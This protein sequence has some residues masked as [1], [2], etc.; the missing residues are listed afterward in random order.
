[1]EQN[2]SMLNLPPWVNQAQWEHLE[3]RE[4]RD[5]L[6][7][8][9]GVATYPCGTSIREELALFKN[10]FSDIDL[11]N[12]VF[13]IPK[14]DIV[15]AQ[16]RGHLPDKAFWELIEGSE[17]F[18]KKAKE[19]EGLLGTAREKF[20]SAGEELAEE[21]APVNLMKPLR[22]LRQQILA[23]I[24]QCLRGREY[25]YNYCPDCPADQARKMLKTE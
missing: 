3:G 12:R 24:D 21:L 25:S 20:A 16:L 10:S 22:D 4:Q 1:M 18:I 15:M 6:V 14:D 23:R 7:E 2:Q 19:L 11:Q 9:I 8:G 5:E 17:G 13:W